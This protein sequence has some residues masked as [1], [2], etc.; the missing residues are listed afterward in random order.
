MNP[1]NVARILLIAFAVVGIVYVWMG[2]DMRNK[3]NRDWWNE[4]PRSKRII[5]A[6]AVV[7]TLVQTLI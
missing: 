1:E 2:S 6:L 5:L 3:T 7:A 4:L